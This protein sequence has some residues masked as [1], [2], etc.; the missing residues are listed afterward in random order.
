MCEALNTLV[1]QFYSFYVLFYESLRI[2]DPHFYTCWYMTI[3]YLT[4]LTVQKA[5]YKVLPNLS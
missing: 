3:F 2:L 5:Y 4:A 1:S